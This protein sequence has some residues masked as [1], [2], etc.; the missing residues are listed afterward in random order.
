VGDP[1]TG[2]GVGALALEVVV[3]QAQPSD[4]PGLRALYVELAEDRAD[5]LP[6]DEVTMQQTLADIAAQPHRHLLVA[7]GDGEEIVGTLDVLIVSNLTHQGRP[8][9][10]IE[11]VA[12]AARFRRHGIGRV[13][14]AEAVD[15]ARS[16]GCYKVQLLSGKQRADEAHPFYRSL[17][18]E[19]IAEGFKNYL[20]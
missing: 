18:F 15:T 8:W 5:A 1:A 11:N 10:I 3:R 12:V 7:V 14:M 9:A 2:V 6:A 16:E 19:A 17:G 4:A 13:L 20:N